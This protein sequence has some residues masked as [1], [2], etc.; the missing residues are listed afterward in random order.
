MICQS[1]FTQKNN[2]SRHIKSV[3][4]KETYQCKICDYQ[5]TEKNSLSRHV[6]NVH[7]KS[8]NINC[9]E[10]DKSTQR[11]SLTH[12]MKVFHSGEHV[13]E[14]FPCKI[15]DYQFSHKRSLSTHVQ[16]VHQK[17]DNINCTECNKSIQKRCLTQ[18]MKV[19]H[20]G[21]QTQFNCNICTFVTIHKYYLYTHVKGVHKKDRK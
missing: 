2:L 1:T 7:Q 17:S 21:E 11:K 12:H 4:F 6:K 20:T 16:N 13:K 19:F 9:T 18:H 15:C 14:K 5:A 10:C 8:E 3:H